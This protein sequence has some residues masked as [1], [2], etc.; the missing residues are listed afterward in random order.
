MDPLYLQLEADPLPRRRITFARHPWRPRSIGDVYPW[1]VFSLLMV[2]GFSAKDYGHDSRGASAISLQSKGLPSRVAFDTHQAPAPNPPHLPSRSSSP[3]PLRVRLPPLVLG[4]W[5]PSSRSR[6][7]R[8][9]A[10]PS[11]WL[12]SPAP[13]PRHEG[14]VYGL[15]GRCGFPRPSGKGCNLVVCFSAC[16]A[17]RVETMRV[18]RHCGSPD[19]LVAYQSRGYRDQQTPFPSL[20]MASRILPDCD[21]QWGESHHPTIQQVAFM[22]LDF[23]AEQRARDPLFDVFTVRIYGKWTSKLLSACCPSRCRTFASWP[24]S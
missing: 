24:T 2:S 19:P 9:S 5:P 22:V 17:G 4:I 16:K 21:C 11:S 15:P 13:L 20:R 23:I 1:R 3:S 12:Q 14:R 8:W 6:T 18:W 7:P 10:P